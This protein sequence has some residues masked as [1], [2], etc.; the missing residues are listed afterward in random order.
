LN[1]PITPN[2]IGRLSGAISRSGRAKTTD[3]RYRPTGAAKTDAT[4]VATADGEAEKYLFYRGVGNFKAPLSI[5]HNADQQKL[6][7]RG[8]F[9]RMLTSGE[10]A[11][12]NGAWLV[13][14]RS[15]GKTAYRR[16]EPFTATNDTT[17]VIATLSSR[18]DDNDY[19]AINIEKLRQDMHTALVGE[20][21]FEDEAY[22]MLR[23]WDRAYFQ[24]GRECSSPCRAMD[25]CHRHWHSV[26]RDPAGHGQ[27]D[28]L[29]TLN[30]ARC[31]T[32]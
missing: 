26:R 11:K 32:G 5:S 14:I 21:L 25:R 18:F 28:Q 22:A 12:I 9:S 17:D 27:A 19:K 23:T 24:P 3:H 8:N 1:S 2:T 13:H 29:V 10:Q 30:S 31:S 16:I 6:S 4:P 20:G 7:I 15:D